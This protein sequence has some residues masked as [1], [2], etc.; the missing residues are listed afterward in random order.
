MSNLYLNIGS[1]VHPAPEPWLNVD[2]NSPDDWNVDVVA[3]AL[4]LPFEDGCADRVYFGH[5]LEHLSYEVDAPQALREAWRVL[6][7]GGELGVV[8]PAMD[9]A[10]K[11]GQPQGI[12][13]AIK[14]TPVDPDYQYDSNT[15]AGLGHLWEA[16]VDNTYALVKSVF[17]NAL[18]VSVELISRQ[19]Q[20]PNTEVSPWQVAIVASKQSMEES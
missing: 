20:W 5:I 19:T 14:I 11:T 13:D 4:D 10:L 7:V 1:G 18:L 8:G 6:R 2:A 16:N 12:I 17:P 9:L 3:S 15:P